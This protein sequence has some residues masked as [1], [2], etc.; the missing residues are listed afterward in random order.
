VAPAR[1]FPSYALAQEFRRM[2]NTHPLLAVGAVLALGGAVVTTLFLR[3]TKAEELRGGA[4]APASRPAEPEP[5]Q[6]RLAPA[7]RVQDPELPPELSRKYAPGTKIPITLPKVHSGIRC[8]DGSFLP[9]LNG[10]PNAPAIHRDRSRGPVP[11]VRYLYIDDQGYQWYWH[12][13]GSTTTSRTIKQWDHTGR[14]STNI[15]TVHGVPMPPDAQLPGPDGPP[16]RPPK[17]QG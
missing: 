4:P 3:N 5:A 10:V 16:T 13:D 12:E 14:E 6:A 7:A 8:P 15:E 11:P 2:T 9:L 1:R 17:S